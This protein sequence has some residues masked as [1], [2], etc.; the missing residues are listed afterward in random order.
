VIIHPERHIERIGEFLRDLRVLEV[1]CG[2]GFRSKQLVKFCRHLV[3]VDP[4]SAAI[5]QACE[6]HGDLRIEFHVAA[7]EALPFPDS[8][9]GAVLFVL[10]LHH[11]PVEQMAT[12]IDEAIRVSVPN[13]PIIFIEPGF[14]GSF[15]EIDE[16]TGACDGDERLQKAQAYA[17]IL[18]HSGLR[19]IEQF[20]DVTRYSFS[21]TDDFVDEFELSPQQFDAA[22]AFLTAEGHRLEGERRINVCRKR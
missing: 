3:G 10:S 13:A 21:S 6:F 8:S 5:T 12:A 19:E 9:F 18:S 17:S 14:R 20:W 1:G 7:A 15:F 22:D 2:D 4:N 16:K 11:I